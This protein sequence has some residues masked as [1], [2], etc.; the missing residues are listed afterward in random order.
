MSSA[1]VARAVEDFQ[2]QEDCFHFNV[3]NGFNSLSGYTS[4]DLHLKERFKCCQ[5]VLET[6]E[7]FSIVSV[8]LNRNFVD[9]ADYHKVT[10]VTSQAYPDGFTA[11]FALK[12][13]PWK[14]V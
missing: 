6:F 10:L 7:W 8:K 1:L 14:T 11:L 4:K 13:S 3:A 2:S 9:D 5:P 12:C